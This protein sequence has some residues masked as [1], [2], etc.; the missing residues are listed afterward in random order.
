MISFP[1][2]GRLFDAGETGRVFSLLNFIIFLASFI[3]QWLVGII[4]NFY[5][6]VDGHFAPA[7]Y[8]LGLSM[9]LVMNIAAV[10]HL[11]ASIPKIDRLKKF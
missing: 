11:H 8:R 5:P 2:I 1:I 9:I 10:I 4:L 7:G 3:A 6:I